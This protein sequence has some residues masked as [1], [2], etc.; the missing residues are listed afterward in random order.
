MLVSLTIRQWGGNKT[1]KKVTEEVTTTKRSD[2]DAGRWVTAM[3]PKDALKQVKRCGTVL[4]SIH[5]SMTLP[6]NG[7]GTRILPSAILDRYTEA[8][9]IATEQFYDAVQDFVAQYPY[10]LETAPRRL[11]ELANTIDM[12]TVAEVNAKYGVET[13]ILPMPS[14]N[15]FRVS[16]GDDREKQVKAK[17]E[18]SI[19][20]MTNKAV[21]SLWQQLALLVGKIAKTLATEDKVFRDSLIQNL[22]DLC[23]SIPALNIT[24]DPQLEELRIQCKQQLASIEPQLLRDDKDKRKEVA[25]KATAVL[26]RIRKIDLDLQ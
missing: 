7:D 22:R 26:E 4:R 12:P 15:D 10:Y 9:R 3:L 18:K 13:A 2:C 16:L 8:I 17:I 21:S 1:D 19:A 24:D 5:N 23:E 11:G 14:V 6:W 20:D 25:S